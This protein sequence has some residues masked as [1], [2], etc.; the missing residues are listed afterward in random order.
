[1][2]IKKSKSKNGKQIYIFKI[3][4]RNKVEKI[5]KNPMIYKI[6]KHPTIYKIPKELLILT[7]QIM[8]P[9][10]QVLTAKSVK[11]E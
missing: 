9:I 1:L 7:I 10:I 8:I 2:K 11:V 6:Q 3:F 4:Q 5:Q